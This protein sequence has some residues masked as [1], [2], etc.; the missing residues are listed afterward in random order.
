MVWTNYVLTNSTY[1]DGIV[2]TITTNLT[3]PQSFVII[4]VYING[5][6]VNEGSTTIG[7]PGP[8]MSDPNYTLPANFSADN[9]VTVS[10]GTVV[11]E[12]ATISVAMWSNFSSILYVDNNDPVAHGTFQ[13]PFPAQT[14]LLPQSL[15]S[16]TQSPPNAP[17]F[18]AFNESQ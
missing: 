1:I 12:G 4:G 5:K 15:P 18:W 13:Y 7:P 16:S 8:P 9:E 3:S 6:L 2:T 14:S 11:Q 10:M 17:D